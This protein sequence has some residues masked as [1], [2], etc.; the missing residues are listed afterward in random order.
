MIGHKSVGDALWDDGSRGMAVIHDGRIVDAND[1]LSGWLGTADLR[2][3]RLADLLAPEGGE[4]SPTRSTADALSGASESRLD[5]RVPGVEGAD[6]VFAMSSLALEEDHLLVV[7][8]DVTERHRVRAEVAHLQKLDAVGSLAGSLAHDFNNL[9]SPILGFTYL[10]MEDVGLSDEQRDQLD[11]VRVAAERSRDLAAQLLALGRNQVLKP[12]PT[13]LRG[14]AAELEGLLGS[15]LREDIELEMRVSEE[16]CT[17]MVDPV[18]LRQML[19]NLSTNAQDAMPDGGVLTIGIGTREHA[20]RHDGSDEGT[21][22]RFGEIVVSDTGE[23][24]SPEARERLFEPFFT[25]KGQFGT[26]LGLASVHGIIQQHAGDIEVQSEAGRGTTF[27]LYLPLTDVEPEPTVAARQ[28]TLDLG[29]AVILLVEDNDLVLKLA[30]KVLTD[31]G[32]EVHSAATGD[33][34]HE[35]LN[36]GAVG[37]DLLLTDVVLPDTNGQKLA[38]SALALRPELH[39][40]YMSGYT[41]NAL[42]DRGVLDP[43][44]S[45]LQKPFSAPELLT[46]VREALGREA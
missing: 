27:K 22:E 24:L 40:L 36:D 26:G 20:L 44:V 28:A 4:T 15:V 11:Q 46:K 9:L 17:V 43:T 42:A 16:P 37:I 7:F 32:Y 39:V 30:L 18:H 34:A 19:L 23:G 21:L 35:V 12:R 13:D 45:F 10:L 14:A 3:R 29:D 25:T 38:T 33:D 6:R 41:N 31:A 2:T 5:V 1:R 8:E